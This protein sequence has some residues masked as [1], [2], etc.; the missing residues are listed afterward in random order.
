MTG[1]LL[2]VQNIV[3]VITCLRWEKL[4][5]LLKEYTIKKQLG[6]LFFFK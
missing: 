6:S 1:I 4:I 3:I 2:I 5:F